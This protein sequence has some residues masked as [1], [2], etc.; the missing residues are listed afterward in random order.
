MIFTPKC[1]GTVKLNREELSTD[2]GTCIH[3]G[4]CGIGRRA[5]YLNSFYIDRM[6]YVCIEDISRIFK[7]VAISKNGF[8]GKGIFGSM[9]Y[10]VVEMKDGSYKQ[11]NFKVEEWVDDFLET[12][13]KNYPDIPIHSIASQKKL[14]E[15]EAQRQARYL[16]QLS[17]EAE[18]ALAELEKAGSILEKEPALYKTLSSAARQKRVIDHINPTYLWTAVI[19]FIMGIVALVYGVLT[20]LINGALGNDIYFVLLGLAAIF[21]I[22]ASHI[23]PT[24]R[25]NKKAANE[26][27][28]NAVHAMQQFLNGKVFPIPSH[29]A[30][31]VLLK[32]MN[33]IIREGRAVNTSDAFAIAMDDLKALNA[34]VTVSQEEYDEVKEIKPLF[35]VC[36]YK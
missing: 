33:R 36:D 22:A 25:R 4:P 31:P 16:K 12:F 35:L 20:I 14:D 28:E 34:T 6:Y 8:T 15:A 9:A 5:L 3:I 19:V 32:R 21:S 27:W 13:S 10:L 18:S 2:K 26:E 29:Y 7:R 11:C 1:L 23:L 17:S 24:G 30:H